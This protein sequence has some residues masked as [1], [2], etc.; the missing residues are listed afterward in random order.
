[1]SEYRLRIDELYNG[2][3]KYYV[4]KMYLR[5]TRG[6]VQRQEIEWKDYYLSSYDT[7][8]EATEVIKF[9]KERDAERENKRVKT[10]TYKDV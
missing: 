9:L 4:Q 1:M 2:T 8:E 7:E 3:K 10:T 6:W 5:I